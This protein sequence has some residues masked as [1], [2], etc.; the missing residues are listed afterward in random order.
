MSARPPSLRLGVL[1]SGTGSTLQA[2]DGA[3]REGRLRAEISLVASDRQDCPAVQHARDAGLAVFTFSP[4]EGPPG[5]WE[6]ALSRRLE[7]ERVDLVVLAGFLR[8]LHDPFLVRWK[9]RVIN[10]H[11]S[12]LPKHGGPGMY[13]LRVH[14]AV[15]E[16]REKETGATIHVVTADLDRGPVLAQ[17]NLAVRAGET[18]QELSVRLKPVEHELLLRFLASVV[19]GHVALP[20]SDREPDPPSP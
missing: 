2:L 14:Q 17:A 3:V 10:T 5:S 6:T 11:P 8:V 18:P 13:G 19:D 7:E 9:G 16:A 20:L 1:V 15:L 4:K 12:L